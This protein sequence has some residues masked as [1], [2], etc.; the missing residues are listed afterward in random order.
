MAWNGVRFQTPGSWEVLRLGKMYLLLE[1][2][3]RPAMEIKWGRISGR[4][5]AARQMKRLAAASRKAAEPLQ[6]AAL[7]DSWRRALAPYEASAFTWA[8]R[9]L[10]A[11]GVLLYCAACSR[12]TLV[13]FFSPRSG[14]CA[15]ETGQ[16]L[17]SFKDHSGGEL[18]GWRVFDIGIRLPRRYELDRFRFEPGRYRLVFKAGGQVVSLMRWG[19]A[20]ALIAGD[21]LPAFAA[22]R[23]KLD[24]DR[25]RAVS[26]PAGTA[27]QWRSPTSRPAPFWRNLMAPMQV[28]AARIWHLPAKNRI[29][30]VTI[31]ARRALDDRLLNSICS[32]YAIV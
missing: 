26:F 21:G 14:S 4:F 17:A 27:L 24:G 2:R 5:S 28:Q 12:V 29:L 32:A 25:W 19:P 16:I 15:D 9:H 6:A 22:R 13:Q 8:D 31:E 30:A 11:S 18:I 23:V 7:P 1:S 10:K 3:G 20:D